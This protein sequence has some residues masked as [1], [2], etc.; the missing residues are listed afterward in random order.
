MSGPQRICFDVSYTR[1]QPGNVG[2]T[3]TVRKLFGALTRT[4]PS[5]G[6]V[7]VP[8]SFHSSG[9]RHAREG[10][11]GRAEVEAGLAAGLYRRLSGGALR[12]VIS[13]CV[14]LALLERAWAEVSRRTFDAMSA[15]EVPVS[16]APGDWLVLADESWNYAAWRGAARARE[17][18]ARVVFVLYDLIPLREPIYCAPLFVRVFPRWL[19]R[20]LA[21][22]DAV[23]CISRATLDDLQSYCREHAITCPPAAHFR[24]GA[25]MPAG[26]AGGGRPGVRDFFASNA[27]CFAAIGSIEP[28]KNHAL[29][30]TVFE[31]LWAAGVDVRLF[32]AGRP[33]AD[34][35]PLAR[36]MLGHPEQGR[37]LLTVVDASDEEIAIAY[38][39]CRALLFP[40][41]AEGFGLPIA[42]ARARG[43][44]V[45]ASDLPAL[46]ELA[47]EGVC[48]FARGSIDEL[49]ALVRQYAA[50][51]QRPSLAPASAFTWEDSAQQFA[52]GAGRLLEARGPAG[53]QSDAPAA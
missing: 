10:P 36:R 25:D 14:P 29:L 2:I 31:R 27:P 13:A 45:I 23:M 44:P 49:E 48:F 3:R 17:S 16:F 34:G 46:R 7:C 41:L 28:R 21:C 11:V 35:L 38:A 39:K 30:L 12:R 51:P 8:V 22:S 40:S 26:S 33:H 9:Y 6:V 4:P 32:I 53:P 5:P 20:M 24:L 50:L 47:D 18:G 19:A 43:C 52:A 15:Q 37:R 42:E 1:T